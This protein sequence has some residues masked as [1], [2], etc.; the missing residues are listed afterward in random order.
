MIIYNTNIT[1]ISG[2]ILSAFIYMFHEDFSSIIG[3]NKVFVH[4][5]L[6]WALYHV[7]FQNIFE[8]YN[9]I[10]SSNS[11]KTVV[12]LSTIISIREDI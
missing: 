6:H 10:S 8:L 9:S 1:K 2:V 12:F 7:W 5:T 4:K 3:I 11:N